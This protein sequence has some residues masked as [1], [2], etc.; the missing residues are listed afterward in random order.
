MYSAVHK[1]CGCHA[2]ISSGFEPLATLHRWSWKTVNFK[3]AIPE[4]G[5]HISDK[6]MNI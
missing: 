4:G 1:L 2:H 6:Q 5:V 3:K